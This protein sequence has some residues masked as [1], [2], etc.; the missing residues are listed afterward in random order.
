MLGC[1]E[2]KASTYDKYIRSFYWAATALTTAGYGDVSAGT[3][4]EQAFSIFVL[5]TGTLLFA[6]VI[7]NLEEIVAQVDVTS[8]LFQQKVDTVNMFMKMRGTNLVIAD[9]VGRY[10][11]TLWLKQKGA[12]ETAVLSYLPERI[13]HEVLKHHCGKMLSNAP[14]FEK[15]NSTFIDLVLD[16]L[17]SDFFL[18][19]D[20]LYEKGE[21]A[22]EL[23][24][25]TRGAIDL[26]DG[27]EKF[28]TVNQGSLLGEGEFFNHEPRCSAAQ[29][30]EYS[31][32]FILHHD[33]LFKLLGKDLRHE[34]IFFQQVKECKDR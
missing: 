22:F 3:S 13:R 27:K 2:T 31:S 10:Y 1:E 24:L 23:F 6:T 16:V 14:I 18:K 7:A 28:M 34:R 30:A 29:A 5:V 8:T 33:D 20:I 9:E 15:F 26:I 19:G 17:K 32:G 4:Y 21:C 25:I 12:S 11:D